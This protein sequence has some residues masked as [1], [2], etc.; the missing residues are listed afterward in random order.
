[1]P[2][3][4]RL[5]ILI[6]TLFCDCVRRVAGPRVKHEIVHNAKRRGAFNFQRQFNLPLMFTLITK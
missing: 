4:D 2:S 6:T 5:K 1:M 3:D